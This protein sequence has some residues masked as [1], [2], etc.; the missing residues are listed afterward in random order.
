[1]TNI[2]C[3]DASTEACSV[4][5]MCGDDIHESYQVAP[6]QHAKLLLP[7]VE[8]QLKQAQI[9]LNEID[10]IACHIGPGAFTGIRIGVSVAQGLAYG[11][12][13]PTIPVSGLYSL[14]QQA[15]DESECDHC[16]AA[17]DARMSEVYFA[18]FKRDEDGLATL[19]GEEVVIPPQKV[20]A[21]EFS[22][23]NDIAQYALIGS[24]WQAYEDVLTA[25]GIS[26][27][28]HLSDRFPKASASLNWA[29]RCLQQGQVLA[30]DKLQPVYL[31]NKVAEKSRKNK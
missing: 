8:Q 15:F 22:I 9:T 24:G 29:K 12:Q 14:A 2:L 20:N 11:A 23:L 3:I 4:A 7:L 26:Y 1:M 17:I 19:V 13:L 5:L 31:R 6:R 28:L 21:S 30:A 16:L 18:I 10:A 25:N 27:D